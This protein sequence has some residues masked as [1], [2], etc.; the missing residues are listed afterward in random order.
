MARKR[1]LAPSRHQALEHVLN[2]IQQ[3]AGPQSLEAIAERMGLSRAEAQRT[4]TMGV[5]LSPQRFQATFT[6]ERAIE[7]LTAG[8]NVLEAALEAGLSGPGRLHDLLVST[9]ALTPG[10]IARRGQGARLAWGTGMT[11]WGRMVAGWGERGLVGL[12]FSQDEIAAEDEQMRWQQAWPEATWQREDDGAAQWLARVEQYLEGRVE[13][14]PLP[15]VLRGTNFQIRVWEALLALPE[16]MA[17]SYGTLAR[18][19]GRP[20]GAQAVGQAVG[21]NLLALIIPCHRV[22]RA[23]GRLGGYRWGPGRKAGLWAS[24]DAALKLI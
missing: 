12:G 4:F 7:R 18:A 5:G 10:Q 24:E 6:R 17:T 20:G 11:R 14:R 15:V 21:A 2:G 1:S 19:A 16:G 23:N 22:I 8:S 13:G 3:A 9:V